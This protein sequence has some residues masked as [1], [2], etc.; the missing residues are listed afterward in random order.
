MKSAS[1]PGRLRRS[2]RTC[3]ALALATI[4]LCYGAACRS[5]PDQ[6]RTPASAFPAAEQVSPTSTHEQAIADAI[7]SGAVIKGMTIEQVVLAHGKP[8]RKDV[9][10]PD[11]ELWH[12]PQGQVAFSQGKVSYSDLDA[13]SVSPAASPHTPPN[14]DARSTEGPGVSSIATVHTPGDGFLALRSEP[15]IRRGKRLLKIP[16]ATV[17]TL[18][19]C[20]TPPGDGR[21]CRT[22]F[23]GQ[24]GWVFERYLVR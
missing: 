16:H 4:S 3:N 6:Q 20:V 24:V 23:Q 7:A 9:I 22:T 1:L 8:I 13:T 10:P 14:Q 18:S 2:R 21:W 17:L 15:T 11:A 12:Y 5:E 19:E